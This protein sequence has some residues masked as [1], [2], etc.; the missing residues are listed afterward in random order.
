MAPSR[1]IRPGTAAAG[2]AS[3]AALATVLELGA[4]TLLPDDA[5][6]DWL[7]LPRERLRSRWQDVALAVAERA[8][9]AGRTDDAQ[10]ALERVLDRDPTDEAAHR[11]LIRLYAAQGRHH[12]AR[13][14]FE[15][16]RRA[17]LEGLD[18]EPSP[19][20]VEALR[21]AE[22]GA[23]RAAIRPSASA[24]A[25]LIGRG[26]E[27][28]RVEPLLDRVAD[29]RPAALIVS[30]PT[31]VGKTRLLEAVREYAAG[32]GWRELAW[33]AT[34]TTR[35]VAF[36]PFATRFA[37]LLADADVGTWAEPE[38]SA[39]A[40]LAPASRSNRASRSPTA[41]RSSSR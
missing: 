23:G 28:Q 7:T 24:T 11:F 37:G 26:L 3:G 21:E 30:G 33:Q 8:V 19:E 18:A 5:Y 1:T 25:P 14:Q 38:R 40:T 6:E 20:T 32:A 34:E 39:A 41:R 17:L 13:R 35:A 4:R 29:G 16:C 9:G 22:Q 36:G 2:Q 15:L 10:L 27:L 31:G 12:A